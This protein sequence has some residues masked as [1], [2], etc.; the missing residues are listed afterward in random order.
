MP[1]VQ[2]VLSAAGL[3]AAPNSPSE[4]RGII[5]ADYK[6]WGELIKTTGLKVQ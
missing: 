6:K 3:E 5:E 2:K 1:D 4:M